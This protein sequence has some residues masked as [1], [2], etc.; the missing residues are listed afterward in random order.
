MEKAV[1]IA[2]DRD[3]Q[4]IELLPDTI[5]LLGIGWDVFEKDCATWASLFEN[6]FQDVKEVE[7][8]WAYYRSTLYEVRR[9]DVRIPEY[10]NLDDDD[11]NRVLRAFFYKDLAD[12]KWIFRMK[13]YKDLY[14]GTP[15]ESWV[16]EDADEEID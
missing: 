4:Q 11:R 15:A 16:D 3:G 13:A 10:F 9:F 12:D 14:E 7:P 6:F 5:N 2:S 8:R 1:I